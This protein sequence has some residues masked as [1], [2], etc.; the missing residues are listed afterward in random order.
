VVELQ[1]LIARSTA[2]GFSM[3]DTKL[4]GESAR[5]RLLV[6]MHT[7]RAGTIRLISAREMT[8]RERNQYE[9]YQA[10]S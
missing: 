9:R 4:F 2:A 10:E 6:V 1:D 3:S 5:G 8:R 7:E